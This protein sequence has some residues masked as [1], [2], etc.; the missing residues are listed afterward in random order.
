ME[1]IALPD[2]GAVA[3]GRCSAAPRPVPGKQHGGNKRQAEEGRLREPEVEVVVDRAEDRRRIR[4]ARSMVED[5]EPFV[6]A[7]QFLLRGYA[8]DAVAD[9]VSEFPEEG[10]A[11][12]V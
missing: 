11:P 3:S 4:R 6:E 8:R 2:P 9:R 10:L 5:P 12:E 7:L 1:K